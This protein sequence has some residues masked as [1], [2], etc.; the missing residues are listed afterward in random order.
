M[1]LFSFF[2]AMLLLV[3]VLA[4][5]GTFPARNG[6]AKQEEWMNCLKD[7][8]YE[9]L[10]GIAKNGLKITPEPKTIV[11]VGAGISGLTAAKLLK[12]AGHQVQILEASGDVGGRI[13]TYRERDWYV[14]LG[15]MRLPESHKIVSEYLKKFNLPVSPFDPWDKNAWYLIR[16]IRRHMKD[17]A[18]PG[19]F[20]YP[21]KPNEEGKSA[22]E[23]LQA[24]LSKE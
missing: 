24:A 12:D 8:D 6:A 11:I 17:K 14:D 19:I 13:K 10:V 9:L 22:E 16:N 2:Q 20:G 18:S 4:P 21:V 1:D 3:A 15:P 5:A 7:S 23:L